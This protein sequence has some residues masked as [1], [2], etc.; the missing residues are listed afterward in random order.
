[1][2]RAEGGEEFARLAERP[3]SIYGALPAV[4]RIGSEHIFYKGMTVHMHLALA[5]LSAL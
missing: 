1:M 5:S 4:H 2:S 3:H